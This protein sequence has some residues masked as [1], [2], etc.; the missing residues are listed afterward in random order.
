MKAA[1]KQAAAARLII[2]VAAAAFVVIGVMRGE[3]GEVL[4]KSI[5]VCLE[6]IGIG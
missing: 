4:K 6:C 3:V 1:C 2:L 5:R